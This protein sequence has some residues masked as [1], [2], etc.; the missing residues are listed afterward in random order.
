MCIMRKYSYSV[1]EFQHCIE[2]D[3][4][5]RCLLRK[6]GPYDLE[7]KIRVS[8]D[9][10][11]I[12]YD[13]IIN[14]YS[15]N[16][17]ENLDFYRRHMSSV[18]FDIN[19]FSIALK[20]SD[21]LDLNEGHNVFGPDYENF[22]SPEIK[23]LEYDCDVKF[24]IL[25]EN[26]HAISSNKVPIQDSGQ[27]FKAELYEALSL[28]NPLAGYLHQYYKG[29]KDDF[30]PDWMLYTCGGYYGEPCS[31]STV[32]LRESNDLNGDVKFFLANCNY[33]SNNPMV[34]FDKTSWAS[35][36]HRSSMFS[37]SGHVDIHESEYKSIG[38]VLSAD[39]YLIHSKFRGLTSPN[40][41]TNEDGLYFNYDIQASG[42]TRIFITVRPHSILDGYTDH[43]NR[44]TYSSEYMRI[45]MPDAICYNGEIY[46]SVNDLPNITMF[47]YHSEQRTSRGVDSNTKYTIGF[48]IEKEDYTSRYDTC[49]N[50]IKYQT[51]WLKERDGSLDDDTGYELVSPRYDLMSN[52]IFDDIM[53]SDH[54]ID[55]INGDVSTHC[56]GHIHL[57]EVGVSGR[58]FFNKISPWLP[59]FY[60]IYVGRI[61]R[62]YCAIKK[63]DDII[64]AWER[65]PD[66]KYQSVRIFD[67][68][69][70]LRIPSAVDNLDTLRW[71]V[72]LL[73]YIC[74]NLNAT[75]MSIM[76]GLLDEKSS[77]Y[78]IMADEYAPNKIVAKARLYAYFA[79][80]MLD[81]SNSVITDTL[82]SNELFNLNQINYLKRIG[83]K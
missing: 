56:G 10:H 58:T 59:L 39:G 80:T 13:Y 42:R 52:K 67:N 78:A 17:K 5:L 32:L 37:T 51:G 48:E 62:R 2:I 35:S 47:G 57:G 27:E 69:I 21:Y 64:K 24:L 65:N 20:A 36:F 8:K 30:P 7:G 46:E 77:L 23:Q 11:P 18:P 72:K 54:L 79:N 45:H 55:A 14:N 6:C 68:R 15:D 34:A 81:I 1:F 74:N 31:M 49:A 83:V 19:S 61:T 38:K 16:L 70:E 60:S 66:E 29:F 33:D 73:R 22:T 28:V 75:P 41:E 9:S 53:S 43:R 44:K 3:H 50:I 40:Y 82:N 71:R 4:D 76:N 26:G 63:N 12:I 25:D